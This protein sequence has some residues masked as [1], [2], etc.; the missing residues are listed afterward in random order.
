MDVQAVDLELFDLEVSD[1]RSPDRKP[2]NGQGADGTGANGRGADRGRAKA[3]RSKLHRGTLLTAR[4]EPEKGP[5]AGSA[6]AHELFLLCPASN[7]ASCC[8][9]AR[10]R[11]SNSAAG[12][13]GCRHRH[14]GLLPAGTRLPIAAAEPVNITVPRSGS[15][16]V[17]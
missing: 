16:E 4:T 17:W 3:S 14:D 5:R 9:A 6:V 12:S 13:P 11:F 10:T 1:N 15:T 2:A 8:W 7:W